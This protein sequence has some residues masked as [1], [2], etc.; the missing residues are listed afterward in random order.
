MHHLEILKKADIDLWEQK[1]I[2]R[3]VQCGHQP[4][5]YPD[6]IS[7]TAAR[8]NGGNILFYR[9]NYYVAPQNSPYGTC[10]KLFNRSNILPIPRITK[11]R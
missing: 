8:P 2:S 1:N 9:G 4:N 5:V 11:M 6:I 3:Y 7:A 10:V